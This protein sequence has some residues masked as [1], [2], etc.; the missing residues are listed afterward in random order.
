VKILILF[1]RAFTLLFL[2]LIL[3]GGRPITAQ[4]NSFKHYSVREGVSQSE[5]KCIYQDSEGFIWFG[6]QNGL[7]RFDGY[8]FEK[9][10][11]DPKDSTSLSNNWIF[12]ITEDRNGFLWL[13]TKGGLN[14]FDK[15]SGHFKVIRHLSPQSLIQDNFVYG[16]TS[17]DSCLYINTP[18]V[19]TILNLNTGTL[20]AYTNKFN[21]DG[22]LYDIGYP[23]IIDTE[24]I[25]WIGSRN[26][27]SCFDP[28]EKH[29]QNFL[30]DELD[31]NSISHDQI[32]ALYEDRSGHMLIGTMNGAN[33]FDKKTKQF[34]Q[35]FHESSGAFTISNNVIRSITESHD[36][37][38]WIGTE[39][40]G[41]NRISVSDQ[42]NIADCIQYR[43]LPENS[44]GISHD[45]VYSLYE[46]K[47]R[48]LWIGT[49]A[50][51]DKLD[52]KRNKFN[53]YKKTDN[54]GSVDLLDNVIASIYKDDQGKLWIGNWNKGLNIYDRKTGQ[55]I[56]Y[57]SSF[58]GKTH[59]PGNNVHVIF[60]DSESRIWLGTR[61]GVSIFNSNTGYFIPFEDYFG[62]KV[63]D[64]F[65]DNRVYCIIE[66]SSGTIW[67]GTG[68]GIFLLN[69][70]KKTTT[71]IHSGNNGTVNITN[72][73]VY[74][75]YED[76]D[77]N[78]W[79]ATSNGLNQYIPAEN[80]IY[81][82]LHNPALKYSLC[83]NF[84]ISV[85]EDIHGNIWIGTTSGVNKFNKADTVFT[86]YS[87]KDGL[88]SNIV[89]DILKDNHH[90]LWFTTGNGLARLDV[91]TG[92]IQPFT[93]EEGVQG[94]EFNIK[95]VFKGEDGELF[96]GG[97]DGFISFYPDS[98]RGN[99]YI[100]PVK[101]TSFEKENDGLRTNVNVYGKEMNLTYRDYSF[102]I[103]FSAL[104]YSDPVK[105][106][107][108]YQM[109]PLSDKWINI[110][111]RRFVHF[112][113]LP[114]GKYI[115]RI[116]GTN[117]DGVWNDTGT[118]IAINISP[119][120]W[121]S[122][123]AF[124]VSILVSAIAIIF[125]I[126]IRERK[127]IEEKKRLELKILERTEEI[128]RQKDKLD[129]LNSTKDKFFSILAHDLKSPFSS[130]YSMSELLSGGYDTLDEPDR[131]TGLLKINKLAELIFRLLENLLMWSR[132][133]R[134]GIEFSPIPFNLSRLVEVNVNLHKLT[135][136]EKGILLQN[137]VEGENLAFG[138]LE[139]I[140]TVVRNLISNAVKFTP[141]NKAVTVEIIE[142]SGFFEVLVKDQGVGISPE[143][144]QKLFHI[145]VK[146]KTTGTA[147]ETGT[148]LGLIICREFVEKNGGK[149]W[150]ESRENFGTTFH[151]SIPRHIAGG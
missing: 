41:L 69:P 56:H 83:D 19:L 91:S 3:S 67:I 126:K 50:G 99:D 101:I 28:K 49:L 26:G 11:H 124:I 97:M 10:F 64:Y 102:T 141:D 85:C 79:I 59:I 104:D 146:Y 117:N 94:M 150:C 13:G 48:N 109:E 132:S 31:P 52:L 93:L 125:F 95:A 136:Q 128:V 46:D 4:P 60:K 21:Y 130:L 107:Y 116:K 149:I 33:I 39:E 74:S 89:Y 37:S 76:K 105:N 144:M 62:L 100:P 66:D 32:T 8:S 23:I 147:G 47:S 82:Y 27:L 54:P 51:I 111:N 16:V 86:Y 106:Q 151:F 112:T 30:H 75:L 96:F 90:D 137:K 84:T 20:R 5:I 140:N 17:D 77:R 134:G 81:H 73:L 129:E 18:P 119:P 61:N 131:R 6:T 118:S 9:Y 25:I 22:A 122:R 98:L 114:P 127:L 145:D 72:N 34:R 113:N 138:D 1:F 68:N 29:F 63:S 7:N 78:I 38:I 103:E 58:S 45:I 142:D 70:E 71:I 12:S 57:S 92:I 143:N 108:A 55:V 53:Y 139:M 35:W 2:L 133:Q 80:K 44:N 14:R 135:A 120:W 40:G 24:G 42:G 115:F 110:G 148:G 87:M 15:K 88:P 36:G 123:W 121:K 65:E 43:S